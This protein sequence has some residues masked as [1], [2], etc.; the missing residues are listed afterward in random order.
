MCPKGTVPFTWAGAAD[1]APVRNFL[2]TERH[3][4]T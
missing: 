2:R 1:P 3:G 4:I